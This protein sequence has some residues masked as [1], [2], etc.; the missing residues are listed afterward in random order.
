MNA[1]TL[2]LDAIQ[3]DLNTANALH[4]KAIEWD[5]EHGLSYHLMTLV[6]LCSGCLPLIGYALVFRTNPHRGDS[7]L[8][9][10]RYKMN[11]NAYNKAHGKPPLPTLSELLNGKGRTPP[12]PK[13]SG[14]TRPTKARRPTPAR[15]SQA[16]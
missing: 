16:A 6:L 4:K 14:P 13:A 10:T 5:E 3:S 15:A 12:A 2:S 7:H 9:Y 11:M 1:A 8:H